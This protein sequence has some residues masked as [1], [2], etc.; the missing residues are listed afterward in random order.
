MIFYAALRK[1]L[2]EQWSSYRLLIVAA[3][4]L[5]FGL[6]SPVTAKYTPEIIKLAL[7]NGDE[8]AALLPPPSAKESVEQYLGNLSQ[9]GVVIALLVTMGTV[10]Q[11]KDKGTA[12]LMLVKPLPRSV[13]LLAKL[14]AI[15]LTFTV[16]FALAG[17]ASY[18][19]TL[20]LFEAMDIVNWVAL[21]GL[22]LLLVLIYIA[23]TLLCSTLTKS[24]VAAGGMAFGVMIVLASVSAVPG[25]GQY[26]PGQ[27]IGW[28]A[29][30][31]AGGSTAYWPAL[32][33]SIGIVI[34]A[35]A[36]AWTIFQRQEL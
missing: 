31:M 7:P 33:V 25:I 2:L 13:F 17:A 28:G 10:A 12:A 11:E 19:Y 8:V 23:L 22:M 16:S 3:V 34:V 26:L 18:Y 24:Q 4:L 35:L 30:L 32:G 5:F 29:E 20:V 6:L 1:E 15:A 21:N 9:F 27:L 36:S 14:I